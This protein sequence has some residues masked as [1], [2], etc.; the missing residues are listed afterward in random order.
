[1]SKLNV[2]R[3]EKREKKN[4]VNYFFLIDSKEIMEFIFHLKTGVSDS[5]I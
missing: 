4:R 3:R 2:I 5:C 1:M